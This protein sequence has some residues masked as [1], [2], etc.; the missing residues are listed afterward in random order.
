[1]NK[2]TILW[3]GRFD[4]NYSRNMIIRKH[5][6]DLNYRIIDFRPLMSSIGFLEAI[7]KRIEKPDL[8][9]V[10]CFRH[11]D[12]PSAKKW[13][14][15]LNIK[16]LFDP[17]ISSWDKEVHEKNKIYNQKFSDK[18][19]DKESALFKKADIV[20]SDTSLHAD[21]FRKKLGLSKVRNP[22]VY[23]GAE[24]SLFKPFKKNVTTDKKFDVLF[25]GSFISLHGAEMI[26][27]A[28]NLMSNQLDVKWTLLGNGPNLKECKRLAQGL[29]NVFFENNIPPSDLPER[30]NR[31]DLL[32][33]I[34]GN[35]KKA[36]SVIPNKVFQSLA[37]GKTV[38]TRNS[39]AYPKK[40]S[41]LNKGIIFNKSNSPEEL[42]RIVNKMVKNSTFLHESNKHSR[43]IYLEYFSAKII[44]KQLVNA[45]KLAF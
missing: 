8:I 14:E 13:S 34:F 2:K 24:E 43:K 39:G 5:L 10:P 1:M 27:R 11:R 18:L 25:Y 45:L 9:W 38:I 12:I 16:L 31:A 33:G 23:V 22:I 7:L 29:P 32:L 40:L 28:A 19:K 4:P 37:C 3:W 42:C 6:K 36:R 44:K 17:L 20:I 41:R 15:K 30:I 35:S 26:V 21:L